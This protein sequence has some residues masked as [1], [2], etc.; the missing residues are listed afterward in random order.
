MNLVFYLAF[1]L[2]VTE[3][4]GSAYS[5]LLN[6]VTLGLLGTYFA[7][8]QRFISKVVFQYR[9]P[10]FAL[11]GLFLLLILTSQLR[12]N[13][14]EIG[15]LMNAFRIIKLI[16]FSLNSFGFFNDA[17]GQIRKKKGALDSL[18]ISLLV[19]PFLFIAFNL[20]LYFFAAVDVLGNAAKAT[21]V[22]ESV[23][24]SSLFGWHIE[25]VNF[26]LVTG[27]NSFGSFAG[28]F[29]LT[30]LLAALKLN[31]YRNKGIAVMFCALGLTC[32]ALIDTRSALAIIL[33]VL[34]LLVAPLYG[35]K[36]SFLKYT[37]VLGSVVPI[38]VFL[39]MD[40]FNGNLFL[41]G[42]SRGDGDL[43][44]GN[45]RV[46]IWISCVAEIARFKWEHLIGFGEYG[47]T[48]SGVSNGWANIFELFANA[49]LITTHNLVLQSFFDTG[50]VGVL[51]YV[52]L[53]FKLFNTLNRQ[54]KSSGDSRLLLPVGFLCFFIL[55]GGTE[56][57]QTHYAT[58]HYLVFVIVYVNYLAYRD[59]W[60]EKQTKPISA[61]RPVKSPELI[62]TGAT[63]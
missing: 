44:T 39:N 35:S 63:G 16:L 21:S 53:F 32:L 37:V 24:L 3:Y 23:L 30:A 57:P 60:L 43:K 48:G 40:W 27:I 4:G 6:F 17:A 9:S 62:L 25:R 14:R 49:N 58:L 22:G 11:S 50:Y 34:L 36:I 41:E 1:V 45:N 31:T 51:I 61:S 15:P 19:A 20:F 5:T 10:L 52:L 47:Q 2:L 42:F 7:Y 26:P 18:S 46:F 29:T 8:K 38:L 54:Y 13:N 33:V 28:A 12:T 55:V 56:A 59:Q